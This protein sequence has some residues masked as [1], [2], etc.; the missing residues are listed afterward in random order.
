[1]LV[2]A[3]CVSTETLFVKRLKEAIPMRAKHQELFAKFS[4]T[5]K[6]GTVLVWEEMVKTWERDRTK[7]NPY[8]EP[9]N[10]EFYRS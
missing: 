7:P 3:N 4:A 8:E 9:I 10:G 5:F 2:S 6:P 1:M